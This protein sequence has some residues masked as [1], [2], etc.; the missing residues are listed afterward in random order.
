MDQGTNDS[1][2]ITND[3][4]DFSEVRITVT[5]HESHCPSL[6][7]SIETLIEEASQCNGKN[8]SSIASKCK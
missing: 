1:L 8:K 4:N 6:E 2:D 7:G 3:A 5:T